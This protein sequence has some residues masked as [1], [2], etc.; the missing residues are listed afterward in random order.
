M[1]WKPLTVFVALGFQPSVSVEKKGERAAL[2]FRALALVA[3]HNS[4]LR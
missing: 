4:L 2:F 3:P 1:S